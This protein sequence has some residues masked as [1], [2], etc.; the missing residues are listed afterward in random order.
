[1]KT[2]PFLL[3]TF[4]IFAFIFAAASAPAADSASFPIS[5]LM[6]SPT[7]TSSP[8]FPPSAITIIANRSKAFT[9]VSPD[10]KRFFFLNDY[11]LHGKSN[12]QILQILSPAI[13]TTSALRSV[14]IVVDIKKPLILFAEPNQPVDIGTARVTAAAPVTH[15]DVR[16]SISL[17]GGVTLRNK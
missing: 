7:D 8:A 17:S 10:G 11:T 6:L 4:A 15:L 3:V 2:S 13:T 1:M 9:E 16:S 5:S 14:D 12:E